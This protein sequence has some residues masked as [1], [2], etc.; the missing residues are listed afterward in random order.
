MRKKLRRAY[1]YLADGDYGRI[2]DELNLYVSPFL[3]GRELSVTKVSY[4]EW[5]VYGLKL[6]DKTEDSIWNMYRV[7]K[8]AEF[9]PNRFFLIIDRFTW[10]LFDEHRPN[11][12]LMDQPNWANILV[13]HL[14]KR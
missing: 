6:I 10:N 12:V 13:T 1:L 5:D 14:E 2:E 3:F 9:F 4:L 8:C 7:F 11:M